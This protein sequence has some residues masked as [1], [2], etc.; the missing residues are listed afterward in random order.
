MGLI[1]EREMM[2]F[3]LILLC[4]MNMEDY[5]SIL[6]KESEI[7]RLSLMAVRTKVP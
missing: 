1:M 5:I 7:V 4:Y 6:D 3:L 2:N